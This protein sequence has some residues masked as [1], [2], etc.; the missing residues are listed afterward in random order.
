MGEGG[1]KVQQSSE[2]ST[3]SPSLL[4][5]ETNR[6]VLCFQPS[7]GTLG[8]RILS[9]TIVISFK[10]LV[11]EIL[12][13]QANKRTS[14][15]GAP[16]IKSTKRRTSATPANGVSAKNVDGDACMIVCPPT[17]WIRA[18]GSGRAGTDGSR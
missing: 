11:K 3:T 1:I 5:D 12:K 13:Q 15:R 16:C 4:Y 8:P 17:T 9:S 18:G 2:S 7:K 14:S 6:P 10:I